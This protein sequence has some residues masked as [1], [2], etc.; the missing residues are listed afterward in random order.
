MNIRQ[1]LRPNLQQQTAAIER[2][3]QKKSASPVAGRRTDR[4]AW[5]KQALAF[6]DEQNRR[7]WEKTSEKKKDGSGS[8]L[9]LLEKGL[10]AQDKCMKIFARI[11]NGDIVPPEDLNYLA[12]NDPAALLL[13]M[14]QRQEKPNPKEWESVL[15]EED[16]EGAAVGGVGS[17]GDGSDGGAA[18]G[19][20]GTVSASAD[21]SGR[22]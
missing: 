7:V 13:A 10:K 4:A 8:H 9:D 22:L 18:E 2:K 3:P 19:S 12:N 6:I 1:V 16:R 14:S 17:A 15:D 21:S 11:R 5:S 20:P